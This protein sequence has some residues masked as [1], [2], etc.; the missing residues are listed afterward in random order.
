MHAQ[1]NGKDCI[2][3]YTGF[4]VSLKGDNKKYM[5]LEKQLEIEQKKYEALLAEKSEFIKKYK[6]DRSALNIKIGKQKGIRDKVKNNLKKSL[7]N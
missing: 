5:E 7:N 3:P 2:T 4:T 1:M 6:K